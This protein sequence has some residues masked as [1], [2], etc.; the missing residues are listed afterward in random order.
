MLF[1]SE[2][3][4]DRLICELAHSLLQDEKHNSVKENIETNFWGMF[5]SLSVAPK[6][7]L[8]PIRKVLCH[9]LPLGYFALQEEQKWSVNCL[10]GKTRN[11]EI[12]SLP[13]FPL[14]R[15]G[16]LRL[17]LENK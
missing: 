3:C 8:V 15:K 7:G 17:H 13:S 5:G 10:M 16:K 6:T 1:L 2:C 14:Q 4:K 9:L 12:M 11:S